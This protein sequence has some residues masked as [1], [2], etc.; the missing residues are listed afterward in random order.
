[1]STH[2]ESSG[3][4]E[5]LCFPQGRAIPRT[6]IPFFADVGIGDRLCLIFNPGGDDNPPYQLSIVSPT[7][8]KIMETILRD[9]PTGQPQSAAPVEFMVSVNGVYRIEI[10]EMKGRARGEAKLKV[11]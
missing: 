11:A 4:I 5:V 9:L 8:A 2:I 10:R 3:D 7:G 1:M 6:A